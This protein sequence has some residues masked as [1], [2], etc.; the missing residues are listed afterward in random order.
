[1]VDVWRGDSYET[2]VILELYGPSHE[3]T[4]IEMTVGVPMDLDQGIY[5]ALFLH[6]VLPTWDDGADWIIDNLSSVQDGASPVN[7]HEDM[8]IELSYI[9]MLDWLIVSIT[10]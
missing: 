3:L 6:L 1:M 5:L 8:T 7:H 4:K 9:P 2:L 10:A